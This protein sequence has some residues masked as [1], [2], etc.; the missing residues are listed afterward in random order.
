MNK[1]R[2]ALIMICLF[3]VIAILPTAVFAE[4]ETASESDES[5]LNEDSQTPDMAEPVTTGDEITSQD[6]GG[7]DIEELSEPIQISGDEQNKTAND[8]N[9]SAA[10]EVMNAAD[11]P[12]VGGEPKTAEN[13]RTD[14]PASKD[15]GTLR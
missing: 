9:E 8:K 3:A 11:E 2:I 6:G 14:V 5:V 7:S 13:V 15:E 10:E 4:G 1:K 12:H